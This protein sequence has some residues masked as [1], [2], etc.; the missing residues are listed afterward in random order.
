MVKEAYTR[1]YIFPLNSGGLKVAFLSANCLHE[2]SNVAPGD[3]KEAKTFCIHVAAIEGRIKGHA[4]C[5]YA[6]WKIATNYLGR[7]RSLGLVYPH[8]SL[9]GL[10]LLQKSIVDIMDSYILDMKGSTR[11]GLIM[12]A[13]IIVLIA[14]A[15]DPPNQ[16]MIW[17]WMVFTHL[18]E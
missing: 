6:F 14:N 10:S 1:C 4:Q 17:G 13:V 18:V 7:L 11:C 9:H 12:T 2:F 8:L 3:I 16:L 5:N 15:V